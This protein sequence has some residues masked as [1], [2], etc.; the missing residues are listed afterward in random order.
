MDLTLLT[1]N[2]NTPDLIV[3]LLK[4]V[5][6][7]C[8]KLPKVVVMDTSPKRSNILTDLEIPNYF[9]PGGTHG[10]AVNLGM[11][12]VK[13]NYV[14]LVDSDVIFLQDFNPAFEKFKQFNVTLMGNVV[15]N[16]AGKSL[17]PRVEPWFCFMD[18][19]VLKTHNIKFFDKERTRKSKLEGKRVYDIGSTM[20]EDVLR[21]DLPIGNCN[22]ENKY[23]KHYGGMS[24]HVPKFNGNDGDTDIDFGGTHP[25][26]G[27]L[28][29]GLRIQAQYKEDVR[30]LEDVEIKGIFK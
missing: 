13:T 23:F 2:Y 17:H 19:E 15:G 28:N 26:L 29:H 18:L 24:W 16:C 10:D 27:L 30:V 25:H 7:T 21:E 22:M 8:H 14:L 6:A 3:N 5:K 4:S 12:E 11:D 1:C 9:L 20:F